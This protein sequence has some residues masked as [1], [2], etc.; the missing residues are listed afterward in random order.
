MTAKKTVSKNKKA[1][2]K[3][4]DY[5]P[6]ADFAAA[7]NL[8]KV[9]VYKLTRKGSKLYSKLTS[10]VNCYLTVN[11]NGKM[12]IRRSA[13]PLFDGCKRVSKQVNKQVKLTDVNSNILLEILQK[14][15]EF[16]HQQLAEKD[17]Q[18]AEKDRQSAEDRKRIAELTDKIAE[19]LHGAQQAQINGQVLTAL[20]SGHGKRFY[21]GKGW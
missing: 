8:S 18:L 21:R 3:Y 20:N 17:K 5:M 2:L 19:A 12:L 14:D 6:I 13:M 1:E 4:N 16:L 9:T 15:I 7:A 11:E 10:K